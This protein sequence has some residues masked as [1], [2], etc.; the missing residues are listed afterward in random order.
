MISFSP[1]KAFFFSGFTDLFLKATKAAL[2]WS[3][4]AVIHATGTQCG[5]L[6]LTRGRIMI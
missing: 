2:M 6:I 5:G 3:V 1:Y 4:W